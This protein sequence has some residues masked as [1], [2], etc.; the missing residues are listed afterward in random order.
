MLNL[1][2][3]AMT[4]SG[5]NA[6]AVAFDTTTLLA[7]NGTAPNCIDASTTSFCSTA[8]NGTVSASISWTYACPTDK[9]QNVSVSI[10]AGNRDADI[11]GLQGAT[12]TAYDADGDRNGPHYH[13]SGTLASYTLD[14]PNYIGE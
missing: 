11:A 5:D 12:I 3:I 9:V 13:L 4:D 8:T 7:L 6:I 10:I 1:A 2:D 14:L